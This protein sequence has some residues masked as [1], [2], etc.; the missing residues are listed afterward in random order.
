MSKS[1][2]VEKFIK[3]L[4]EG[5]DMWCGLD[6]E[7]FKDSVFSVDKTPLCRIEGD[8]LYVSATSITPKCAL[9]IREITVRSAQIAPTVIYVP[10][11]YR[12]DSRCHNF[13]QEGIIQA[14]KDEYDTLKD[15]KDVYSRNH[16]E[17]SLK[18]MQHI[19]A[20]CFKIPASLIKDAEKTLK[21]MN[22]AIKIED[23]KVRE[24]IN[25][26]SYY[27]IVEA[28]YFSKDTD[29][30]TMTALRRYLNPSGEYA[31]LHLNKEDLRWYS[32]ET[33]CGAYKPTMTLEQGIA[34]GWDYLNGRAVHGMKYGDYVV[35]KVMENYI[36]ISCN[37]YTREMM[38]A[39]VNYAID[40]K[41]IVVPQ[42][43]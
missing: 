5:N 2:S 16:L 38:R 21:Q 41:L 33:M 35:M 32:S 1:D 17:N 18:T 39:A 30:K 15:K 42:T 22:S 23:S 37:K 26:H 8:K 36:Q 6:G 25:S 28:A 13:S 19:N 4:N 12:C 43:V 24:F 3:E 11:W 29:L 20:N 34:V 10:Q 40:E 9:Y 27:E 7:C 14:F 31:F